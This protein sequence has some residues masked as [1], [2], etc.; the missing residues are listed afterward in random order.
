MSRLFKAA[1]A[2]IPSIVLA[3]SRPL[4]TVSRLSRAAISSPYNTASGVKLSDQVER[5]LKISQKSF[6]SIAE[7]LKEK[8]STDNPFFDYLQDRSKKVG[9]NA[10][11]FNSLRD[12]YFYRTLYTIVS[13]AQAVAKLVAAGDFASVAKAAKNMYEEGGSGKVEDVHLKLLEDCFNTH[14]QTIFGLLSLRVKDAEHSPYLLDSTKQF[15]KLQEKILLPE[16]PYPEMMGRL[17]AHE[18]RADKMLQV[19]QTAFF[20]AFKGYYPDLES[21]KKT[22][23]YFEVH[24]DD[25]KEGGDI[26]ARHARDAEEIAASAIASDPKNGAKLF[27]KGAEDFFSSQAKMWEALL[28]DLQKLETHGVKIPP[29]RAIILPSPSVEPREPAVAESLA[30]KKKVGI[31]A[32]LK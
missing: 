30:D 23:R 21:Y 3:G 32:V 12:N 2:A 25:S 9:F 16:Y 17:W 15:R 26:E 29:N 18:D 10:A 28:Q 22:M 6:K 1:Q 27:K 13:V 4:S 24:R 20:E 11:Q 19:F 5:Q 8:Y 14:G 31:G 7:E